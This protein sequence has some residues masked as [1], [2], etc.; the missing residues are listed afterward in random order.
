[1]RGFRVLVVG[2]LLSVWWAPV[3]A[4]GPFRKLDNFLSRQQMRQNADSG[5]IYRPQQRFMV[6]T[7]GDLSGSFLKMSEIDR[8]NRYDV[9]LHSSLRYKQNIALGYR[10]LV[11]GFSFNPFKKSSDKEFAIRYFGNRFGG[12]IIRG[13]VGSL[14]GTVRL[15]D[16][17][18]HVPE[19]IY[20]DRYWQVG[21]Y[22]VFNAKRF[23]LP[24]AMTQAYIQRRSAG[25]ALVTAS[26]RF[27]RSD[28]KSVQPEDGTLHQDIRS[29]LIGIGGGYGYNWVPSS[30]WL[31]H[32]SATE[33][34]GLWGRTRV[35]TGEGKY[36]LKGRFPQLMTTG[37]VSVVY[38]YKSFYAC[39]LFSVDH[40]HMPTKEESLGELFYVGMTRLQGRISVGYRF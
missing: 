14:K 12:E 1:M 3:R 18:L 15:G 16:E 40:S 20:S 28:G 29:H 30:H 2:L 4:E 38:Y 11:L 21:G 37:N 33:S 7:R 27:V 23:S 8:I 32:L 31:L 17:V 34:F 10:T 35:D 22:Y 5:Y 39:A 36:D 13:K 26:Y 19:S 25:S 6:R 9:D 24:A